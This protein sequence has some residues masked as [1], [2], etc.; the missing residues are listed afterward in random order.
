[1][2]ALLPEGD[3]MDRLARYLSEQNKLKPENHIV[4]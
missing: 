4:S 3:V 1:M 2:I